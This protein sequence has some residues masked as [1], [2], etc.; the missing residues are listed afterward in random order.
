M[1]LKVTLIL[2]ENWTMTDARA[3]RTLVDWAV[4]AEEEGVDSVMLSEHIVLGPGADS[5]GRMANLRDYALPNNQDPAT[6]W[7][8]SLILLS[9]IAARTS[10]IRLVA[11]AII[12]PLRHPLHLAKDLATLDLLSE[13]RLIVIPTVSWHQEEYDAL[14]VPFHLRGQLLDEHLAAWS[15]LWRETPASFV[16]KHYTFR[17][18]YLEPKPYRAG[19]P[20][21][22]FGGS[23]LHDAL[24]KRIV[25]YGSGFN[26]LG[27][28][29]AES[30]QRLAD[31][32]QVAGRTM[33]ELEMVG[34]TRGTFAD[35]ESVADLTQGL[36]S[37][38]SQIQA[39]Y[40]NFCIKPSQY[41]DDPT[42]IRRFCRE[43]VAR[44][45]A[46]STQ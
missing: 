34:G 21:L 7:P 5:A 8:A 16:G 12:A 32:L 6:P 40:T 42:S 22:Y 15:V 13:G 19:G 30:M 17:N 25:Q 31:A 23:T 4:I 35:P 29:T 27:S 43:V 14:G 41:T 2:S 10:R 1:S 26:P 3:L 37:I 28:P 46:L 18:V 38:P 9:A 45:S 20:L 11:G 33:D 39:G 44:L 36:S 24:I